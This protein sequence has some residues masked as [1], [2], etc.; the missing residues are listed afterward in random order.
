[1]PTD[2]CLPLSL[3]WVIAEL[4]FLVPR[5]AV[6][7]GG[8]VYDIAYGSSAERTS[9]TWIYAK[10]FVAKGTAPMV[11]VLWEGSFA[12][13]MS[14]SMGRG[15]PMPITGAHEGPWMGSIIIFYVYICTRFNIIRK[16][17]YS[18]QR[19]H[20]GLLIARYVSPVDCNTR[21]YT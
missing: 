16:F 19:A 3:C 1:M 21:T 5:A 9:K 10:K 6:G 20:G 2:P 13:D 7:L 14:R 15:R 18:I 8:A 4:V 12:A 11:S 17:Y